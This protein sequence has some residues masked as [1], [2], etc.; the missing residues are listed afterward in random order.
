MKKRVYSCKFLKLLE[1]IFKEHYCQAPHCRITDF[2]K[3][4]DGF[5]PWIPLVVYFDHFLLFT[6]DANF[7]LKNDVF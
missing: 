6:L 4:E 2:S 1:Y 3:E 7:S 5:N